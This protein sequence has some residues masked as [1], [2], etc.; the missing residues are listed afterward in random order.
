M[1]VQHHSAEEY[2]G[3]LLPHPPW[4]TEKENYFRASRL[5]L[6]ANYI[7]DEKGH[8]LP[9]KTVIMDILDALQ[10]TANELSEADHL[11]WIKE[12]LDTDPG[13]ARQRRVLETTGSARE[14]VQAL[15][16]ALE[17]DLLDFPVQSQ[18]YVLANSRA[19]QNLDSSTFTRRPKD[20][21]YQS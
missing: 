2:G 9:I 12:H 18:Q 1:Y 13:Y 20:K 4:W 16:Q 10:P 5:G 14:V 8:S 3:F 21:N 6:E 17:T 19:P 15:A 7:L 11:T